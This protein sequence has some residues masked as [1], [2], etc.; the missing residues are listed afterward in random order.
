MAH[1]RPI[2]GLILLLTVQLGCSQIPGWGTPPSPGAFG[3]FP[4]RPLW[5]QQASTNIKSI[6][7]YY[8]GI[9]LVY[10]GT[11]L[12]AY[13]ATDGHMKWKRPLKMESGFFGPPKYALAEETIVVITPGE[14]SAIDVSTGDVLWQ[15]TLSTEGI[16]GHYTFSLPL[17]SVA[18]GG[19]RAYVGAYD[20]VAAYDLKTGN[21]LW[22]RKN[23]GGHITIYVVNG[24]DEVIAQVDRLYVFDA[25]N[26]NTRR[27]YSHLD[28]SLDIAR[29]YRG[30]LLIPTM[31]FDPSQGRLLWGSPKYAGEWWW[32]PLLV[33]DSMYVLGA[34]G[35]LEIDIATGKV[36]QTY[37]VPGSHLSIF[38]SDGVLSDIVSVGKTLYF[39][40]T[41]EC[42]HAVD[43]A[44]M[45]KVGKWCNGRVLHS[46]RS[47]DWLAGVAA[48]EDSLFVSWGT[49]RLDA[50]TA[51]PR[52]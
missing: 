11:N 36:K 37:V 1:R 45:S 8:A 14:L 6:P 27:V 28:A 5:T 19:G 3:S 38:G 42:L 40:G 39:L 12:L 18:V 23:L 49:G 43:M 20:Q 21:M 9:V 41:D 24:D 35:L 48:S 13:A 2:W 16:L 47:P 46:D 4:L 34:E 31:A 17:Y 30:E 50:F 25:S 51:A 26:G 7:V 32:Y 15:H 29:F 33:G 44:P 52:E 22:N 10:D